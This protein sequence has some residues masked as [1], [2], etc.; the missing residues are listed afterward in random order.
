MEHVLW[1][2]YLG[3]LGTA[4]LSYLIKGK[5]KSKLSKIDFVVSVITWIG[6]L[7]YVTETAILNP[8][9]WKFITV[10]ALLWDVLFAM[11]LKDNEG[12]EILDGLPIMTRRVWMLITLVIAIGPLYYGLFRYA[13]S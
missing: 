2:I 8:S 6:L 5:Y 11:L 9:L 10:A 3:L 13:F 12:E 4:S 1:T 7:G